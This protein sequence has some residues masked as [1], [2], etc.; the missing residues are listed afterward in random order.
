LI[1]IICYYI[2]F[3][4][5]RAYL[6]ATAYQCADIAAGSTNGLSCLASS[7]CPRWFHGCVHVATSPSDDL[8]PSRSPFA[9]PRCVPT[10]SGRCWHAD[11]F[12]AGS[13]WKVAR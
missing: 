3:G 13:T 1:I 7:W 11:G 6:A 10:T 8:W 2:I 4:F 12:R 9:V 5:P